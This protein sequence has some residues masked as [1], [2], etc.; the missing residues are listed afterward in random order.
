[1]L[2]GDFL[3]KFHRNIPPY[4]QDYGLI[5]R[6][7][8]LKRQVA[9]PSLQRGKHPEELLLHYENRFATNKNPSDLCHFQWVMSQDTWLKREELNEG[10]WKFMIWTVN[11]IIRVIKTMIMMYPGYW[12][13]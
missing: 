13:V 5:H 8:T 9:V 2:L 6:I 10:C 7:L 1:V 3:P 4:F 12:C 11:K